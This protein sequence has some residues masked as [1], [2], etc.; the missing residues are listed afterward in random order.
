MRTFLSLLATVGFLSV[1]TS[2][3]AELAIGAKAP[4]VS[5]T[6]DAGVSLDLSTVYPKGYTLVYFYPVADAA[7]DTAEALAFKAAHEA[8]IAKGVT[9]LAVGVDDVATIKAFKE[10]HQLPF[11]LIS[12]PEHVVIKA[13]GVPTSEQW[14]MGPR[15]FRQSFLVNKDGAIVWRD[16]KVEPKHAAKEVLK[17]IK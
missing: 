13:F 11:T 15:P 4:A 14:G 5:G 10:K 2:A 17:A 8:F 7:D 6:T 16:L 1:F 12:D 3:R 9:V